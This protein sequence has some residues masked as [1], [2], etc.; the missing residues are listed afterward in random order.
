MALSV[1]KKKDD[2]TLLR[3]GRPILDMKTKDTIG[4]EYDLPSAQLGAKVRVYRNTPKEHHLMV[5]K[6]GTKIMSKQEV[7]N[8]VK[9]SAYS[10][11]S[12][13][14]ELKRKENISNAKQED[15]KKIN[16]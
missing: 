7:E 16:K 15:I 3:G 9:S 13:I 6:K 4:T 10:E 12:S 14:P 8:Y 11:D 2:D 5:P 1:M